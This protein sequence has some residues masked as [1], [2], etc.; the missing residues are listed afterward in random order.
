MNKE[1]KFVY[2]YLLNDV[3]FKKCY[4]TYC[5]NKNKYTYEDTLKD[6]LD[7]CFYSE[8]NP[9]LDEKYLDYTWLYS[10]EFNKIY[11]MDD[12]Y[13]VYYNNLTDGGYYE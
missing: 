8:F 11:N 13:E 6:L 12:I 1:I 10:K 9:Y 3:D 4:D 5:K 2:N 7:Y